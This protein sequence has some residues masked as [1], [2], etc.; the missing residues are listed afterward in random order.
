LRTKEEA[1]E[2]QEAI[3]SLMFEFRFAVKTSGHVAAWSSLYFCTLSGFTLMIWP[4]RRPGFRTRD[5][6]CDVDQLLSAVPGL[7]DWL[8]SSGAGF[9]HMVSGGLELLLPGRGHETSNGKAKGEKTASA[10]VPSAVSGNRFVGFTGIEP[11]FQTI[12]LCEGFRWEKKCVI[13]STLQNRTQE[14]SRLVIIASRTRVS[15]PSYPAM[16]MR[17][18]HRETCMMD[19][20]SR[21]LTVSRLR[22]RY[23][24]ER[25]SVD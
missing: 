13:Q 19:S 7:D 9:C 2:E 3:Q 10:R 23:C 8:G 16:T 20:R 11:I 21:A 18:R 22:I 17:G 6:S 24:L 15:R 5:E 14:Q 25:A 4:K 1:R 12:E